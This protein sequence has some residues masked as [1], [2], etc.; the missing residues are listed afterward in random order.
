MAK[1]DISAVVAS[2]GQLDWVTLRQ[3]KQGASVFASG[4]VSLMPE[5]VTAA[6]GAVSNEPQA[7]TE[8]RVKAE[9]ARIKGSIGAALSSER[10]IIR[11]LA[12]PDA[13]DDELTGMVQL[14]VEKFSPFPTESLI[15]SHEVISRKDGNCQVLVVAALLEEVEA[16]RKTLALARLEAAR[17]DA[18]VLGWCRLLKDSGGI[19][20]AGRQVVLLLSDKVPELIVF[21]DG[22]PISFRTLAGQGDMPEADFMAE[23]A[24]ET[25]FTLMSLEMEH[26]PAASVSISIWHRGASPSDLITRLK[27]ECSAEV[28]VKTLDTLP[29][30]AEGIARR[31]MDEAGG[32]Q[33]NLIPESWRSQGAAASAKFKMMAALF[34]IVGIWVL[35]MG[36]FFGA[37]FYQDWR[38]GQ[39]KKDYDKYSKQAEDV[40]NVQKR[41]ETIQRYMDR[42]QSLL[43]CMRLIASVQPGGVDLTQ[44]SYAK[45]D[46]VS[47]TGDSSTKEQAF[48]FKTKLDD[49]KFFEKTSIVGPNP[50]AGKNKEHFTIDMFFKGGKR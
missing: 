18:A 9:L 28:S 27:E 32:R 20:E 45:G 46:K 21:N 35:L 39:L 17:I 44:V 16:V 31:F 42:S 23:T 25:G 26:G 34:A 49:T 14:Q 5:S 24:R 47:V 4:K 6:D 38:M 41:V 36:G 7:V 12:L 2:A 33:I 10:V 48:D 1:E 15:V 3:G 11:V 43:E 8:G 19:A 50:L 22:L 40:R 37:L 29:S 13:P 30:L